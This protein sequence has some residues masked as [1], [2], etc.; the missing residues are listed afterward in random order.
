MA[1]LT[2]NYGEQKTK[3]AGDRLT[4]ETT[5]IPEWLAAAYVD[6]WNAANWT[7]KRVSRETFYT[8][9]D[10]TSTGVPT[11]TPKMPAAF[12]EATVLLDD[13]GYEVKQMPEI[14]FETKL[15]DTTT[16]RP[17]YYTVVNRQILLWP[18]PDAAYAFKVSYKRRLATR[19]SSG[20]VHAGFY[21]A[22]T[23][24]PL[25]DDHHYI[26]V[27]RAKIL[28]LKLMTDPT[29]DMLQD[30]YGRLMDAMMAEYVERLPRGY[31][32]PAYR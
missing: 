29:A 19:N 26:L 3:V 32:L 9:D 17:A 13:Q 4:S 28:G 21:T 1:G 2:L 27:V 12:A 11:A 6:V 7:F 25:W 14:D 18:T 16:G 30:E 8:T 31:Q 20:T 23:D 10:G 22:D 24:L 5:D 15:T